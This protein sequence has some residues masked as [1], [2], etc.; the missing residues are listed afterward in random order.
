MVA[1][2]RR[3]EGW[4]VNFNRVHQLWKQARTHVPT[5]VRKRRNLDSRKHGASRPKA[6]HCDHV[7][8]Y[9]CTFDQTSA[10]L[11]LKWWPLVGEFAKVKLALEVD[12]Q[13]WV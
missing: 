4:K 2:K 11:R 13:P 5:K 6:T 10:G 3:Q 1:G 9:D 8:S 12:R 7:W